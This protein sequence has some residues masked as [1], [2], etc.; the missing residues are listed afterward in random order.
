MNRTVIITG[1]TRGIGYATAVEFLEHGDR[2]VIVCRHKGHIDEALD[3]LSAAGGTENLLGLTGDVRKEKDVAQVVRQTLARFG[4]ID[5]LVNNAGI[6]AY[7]PL[8][9][10]TEREWDAIIDTNLKGT[11]L[12]LRSVV[13]VMK[14]QK[15]GIIVNISSALGVE[16][17][18]NFSV[19]CASKFGVVGLTRALTD[20][21]SHP[22]IKIYAVLPGAVDTTLLAGSEFQLDP[23]QL[24]KPEHVARKIFQ[25][26]EGKGTSG[27]LIEVYF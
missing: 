4:R 13:P 20:E 10:T 26:A 3:R 25:T 1:S 19:Y 12:F 11:F 2:V 17:E 21:I 5:V 22:G 14:K 9:E 16:G 18:A 27:E 24:M 23:S 6:A 15:K 8:D 7:K